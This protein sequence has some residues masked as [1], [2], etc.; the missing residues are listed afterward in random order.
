MT[1]IKRKYYFTD[2]YK[3]QGAVDY[4]NQ[5]TDNFGNQWI[6]NSSDWWSESEDYIP[7][8]PSTSNTTFTVT[9]KIIPKE[10]EMNRTMSLLRIY[11]IDVDPRVPLKDRILHQTDDFW[12]EDKNEDLY[13]DLN[14]KEK[15]EAHN[16]LRASIKW[17]D[18]DCNG[19]IVMVDGLPPIKYSDLNKQVIN[20]VSIPLKRPIT[21]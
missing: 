3:N 13:Y 20:L 5:W 15:L 8:T 12:S 11:V 10:Q 17:E 7:V 16:K 9:T 2:P 21:D 6:D 19:K 4:N 1:Y 14:L 18:K